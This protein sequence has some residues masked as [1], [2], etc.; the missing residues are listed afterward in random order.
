[1]KRLTKL[2]AWKH[3]KKE[4]K[5]LARVKIKDFFIE[6]KNRVE[7]FFLEGAGINLDFSKNLLT[8]KTLKHL[9]ELARESHLEEKR[10]EMF[11]G[12]KINLSEKRSVLHTALRAPSEQSL[13]LDGKNIIPEIQQVLE[14]ISVVSEKLR[15]GAWL[16]STGK[17]ITNIV[18]IGIGGSDLGPAMVCEA[19][20]P[21]TDRNLKYFFISNVDGTSI[22]E[23]VHGLLPEE[24]LFIVASKTFTTQ[25]TLTNANTA[26][27]WLLKN[28]PHADLAKHFL[29]V[30]AN[31]KLAEEFGI[32]KENI[33]PFWDFVGGRFS[34]WSAIVL[35]IAIAIMFDNFRQLLDGAYAMDQHFLNTPLEKNLPVILA[36][37]G[38]WNIN[39]WDATSL[40]VIPYDQ[41][42]SLFSSYLQQLEMESNGKRVDLNGEPVDYQTAPV[43]W[44]SVGT[45]GQHAYHQLLM[46]GTKKIPI[47]FI[48]PLKSHH[49]LGDHHLF[50][51]AN[52]LAQS[53][54][55][56]DGKEAGSIFNDLRKEG[57]TTD[58]LKMI[59]SWKEILGN[60]PSNMILVEKITPFTLGALIALYEHKVFVQGVI[61]KI[62]SFDQWGVELGKKIAENI[63]PLLR[64]QEKGDNLDYNTLSFIAKIRKMI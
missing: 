8:E 14:K 5:K 63:I 49:S 53:I 10:A 35:I 34:L 64:G 2:S 26:K 15:R 16:G 48:L 9:I 62:N 4:R 13:Y 56:R 24:T 23:A 40:A 31:L 21:Y 54:A 61:W 19:L 27:A 59:S 1:M 7:K 28:N 42:L 25:E 6:D 22:A 37:I 50:L 46:Q 11:N 45:N 3:L 44:G 52:C 12:E 60:V 38:I 30:S 57:L 36:L 39:F 41:Y 43:V 29:A 47:D 33:F 55:L 17:P 51:V 18:N 58:W 32:A 20:K